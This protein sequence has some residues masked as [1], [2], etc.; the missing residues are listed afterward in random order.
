MNY[1]LNSSKGSAYREYFRLLK[2]ILSLDCS[3]YRHIALKI[4]YNSD[5][6]WSSLTSEVAW[7]MSGSNL[8][9]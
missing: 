3:S 2:W 7:E 8:L 9:R 6:N 4:V 5:K 1:S